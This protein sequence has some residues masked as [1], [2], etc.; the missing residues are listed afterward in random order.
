MKKAARDARACRAGPCHA[1]RAL[2]TWTQSGGAAEPGSGKIGASVA[3]AAG[4]TD[5]KEP[6]MSRIFAPRLS[7]SSVGLALLAAAWLPAHAQEG[8]RADEPIQT[9]RPDFVETSETVGKGRFQVETSFL[10]ERERSAEERNRTYSMPTM[11][12]FGLNDAFELRI[13][14]DG[15]TVQH[16]R[17]KESGER[18]TTAGYADTAIGFLW[19]AL[20][21]E[22]MRPSVGVVVGAELPTGS[23]RVRGVGVRPSLRV[24]GEWDLP[25]EMQLGVMPGL[26]VERQQDTRRTTYGLLGISL[27]KSFNRRLH[28]LVEI[29][30]PQIARS[31]DG[32]TQARFDVGATY[33]LTNDCQIDTLFSRGLNHRTPYAS[34]T[35]GLSFRL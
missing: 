25:G 19:H 33:L 22:G 12:R 28:G 24:V 11:L 17:D 9:D 5:P 34:W 10:V 32:G 1:R 21:G 18:S 8:T 14:S 6:R 3:G 27:D 29:A 16:T 23:R 30:M 13:E 31:R 15:R 26:A 2:P 35:V 4:L 20:D 7:R